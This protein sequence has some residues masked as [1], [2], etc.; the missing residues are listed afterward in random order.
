MKSYPQMKTFACSYSL[1]CCNI[2]FHVKTQIHKFAHKQMLL[3][4]MKNTYNL[5]VNEGLGF[6]KVFMVVNEGLDFIEI[7][8]Y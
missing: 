5:L 1:N 2:K 7:F 3:H 6:I 8:T 4:S